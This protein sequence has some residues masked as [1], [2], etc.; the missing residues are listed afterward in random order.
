[1]CGI[2]TT[3]QTGNSFRVLF[4]LTCSLQATRDCAKNKVSA[5][6]ATKSL[7]MCWAHC[8]WKQSRELGRDGTWP[9]CFCH[10]IWGASCLCRSASADIPCRCLRFVWSRYTCGKL[11]NVRTCDFKIFVIYCYNLCLPTLPMKSQRSVRRSCG[12]TPGAPSCKVF[13]WRMYDQPWYAIYVCLTR[14][15]CIFGD[16]GAQ[17][18]TEGRTW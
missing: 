5:E 3:A 10:L 4:F 2:K 9:T 1:M 13:T 16:D 15:M 11:Q 7:W 18:I 17:K 12:A 8:H 14:D 6:D